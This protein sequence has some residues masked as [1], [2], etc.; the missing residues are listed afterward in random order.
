[1]T[2][3]NTKLADIYYIAQYLTV[4]LLPIVEVLITITL[5]IVAI[6]I[7]HD[8]RQKR[9]DVMAEQIKRHKEN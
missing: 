2:I 7:A 1:M 8:N 5:W 4:V 3:T 6:R 9:I